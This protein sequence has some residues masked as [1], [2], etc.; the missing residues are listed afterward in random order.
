MELT[1]IDN[2]YENIKEN[3]NI[4][5]EQTEQLKKAVEILTEI[6]NDLK[7]ALVNAMRCIKKMWNEFILK[8]YSNDK[9]IR[10]L[11]H[12]YTH[13][14]NKRVRKKQMARLYKII[15]E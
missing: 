1:K 7:I 4:T 3:N 14:K 2:I 5:E 10:K 9:T 11:N 6:Y 13:T 12:I 8:I 15:K